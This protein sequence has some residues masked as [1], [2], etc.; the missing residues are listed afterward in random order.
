MQCNKGFVSSLQSSTSTYCFRSPDRFARGSLRSEA[1]CPEKVAV[2]I[3]QAGL[4]RISLV[5]APSRSQG[6]LQSR[7]GE[8]PARERSSHA[9]RG[10]ADFPEGVERRHMSASISIKAATKSPLS[11][12]DTPTQ[13]RQYR[14]RRLGGQLSSQISNTINLESNYSSK[15]KHTSY[16]NIVYKFVLGSEFM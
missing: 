14:P 9:P 7:R 2:L 4:W 12:D 3:Q 1:D 6:T 16:I 13:S 11:K 8:Q 5:N 15:R 10:S